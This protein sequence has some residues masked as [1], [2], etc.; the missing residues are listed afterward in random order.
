MPCIWLERE[1]MACEEAELGPE[2]FA[3]RMNMQQKLQE[4]VKD[5]SISVWDSWERSV[6]IS[7]L[8]Q[9]EMLNYMRSFPLNDQSAILE[10]V[11]WILWC[12]FIARF[13]MFSNSVQAF[14]KTM[15]HFARQ[16]IGKQFLA[17]IT[18]LYWQVFA[19]NL[20]LW[21]SASWSDGESQFWER[22]INFVCGEDPRYCSEK[23]V[24]CFPTEIVGV[25]PRRSS[26]EFGWKT[27]EKRGVLCVWLLLFF[28]W[29]CFGEIDV[30][31]LVG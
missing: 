22:S 13:Y 27:E 24:P 29:S 7:L 6:L 21:F 1:E 15:V 19:A 16:N 12:S 23:G 5:S 17:D 9:L 2:K 30:L 25:L 31:F 28:C 8:Q 14:L 18:C 11:R 4:Q 3:E 20:C 10:K 26:G